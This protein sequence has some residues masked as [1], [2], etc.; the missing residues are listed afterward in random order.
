MILTTLVSKKKNPW[1]PEIRIYDLE[2][3]DCL[4]EIELIYDK[5]DYRED[6]SWRRFVFPRKIY[7]STE[8]D[9]SDSNPW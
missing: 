6:V 7:P 3:L 1:L 4:S 9:N 8:I 2:S 5:F